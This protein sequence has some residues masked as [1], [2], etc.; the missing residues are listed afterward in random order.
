MQ[1][2]Q[3]YDFVMSVFWDY[4][5]YYYYGTNLQ[6]HI[7]IPIKS[8]IMDT[9]LCSLSLYD[10]IDLPDMIGPF[11]SGATASLVAKNGTTWLKF[12]IKASDPKIYYWDLFLY[13][14]Q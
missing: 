8:E 3:N 14:T 11:A 12:R 13:Q 7:F 1:I 4:Y 6:N 5:Y 10:F 9:F 2:S